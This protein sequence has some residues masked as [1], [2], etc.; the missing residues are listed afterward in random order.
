MF[1]IVFKAL[2]LFFLL[3]ISTS[4]KETENTEAL[5]IWAML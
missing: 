3:G 4:K 5:K 1:L 2:L